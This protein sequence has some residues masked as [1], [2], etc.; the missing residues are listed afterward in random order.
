[1]L[2]SGKRRGF[3]RQVFEKLPAGALRGAA[4]MG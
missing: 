3:G 1:M 2:D 4:G